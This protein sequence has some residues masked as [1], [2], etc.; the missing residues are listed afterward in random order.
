[1][2]WV[3][4]NQSTASIRKY[5]LIAAQYT[6]LVLKYNPAQQ[7]VRISSDD[8][9]R[10]YFINRVSGLWH[11]RIFFKNEYGVE[12][13]KLSFDKTHLSGVIE[14][15]GKR[16][17][18]TFQQADQPQLVL[19]EHSIASPIAVCDMQQAPAAASISAAQYSSEECAC[20]LLG[21]CWYLLPVSVGE[22][23]AAV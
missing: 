3:F 11:N 23:Q 12:I 14:I 10:L 7:S 1:M 19:F 17:H 9:H 5:E 13:G 2:K 16:Y 18:Y 4:A 8:H 6:R 21:L 20:F 22:L 15:E